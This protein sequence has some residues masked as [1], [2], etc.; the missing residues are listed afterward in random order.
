MKEANEYLDILDQNYYK[1]GYL[2]RQI[3]I[4]LHANKIEPNNFL[5]I[6]T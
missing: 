1:P 2:N 4:L 5:N 3:V 6:Q